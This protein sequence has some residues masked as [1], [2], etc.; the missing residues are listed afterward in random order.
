VSAG[1]YALLPLKDS[2]PLR[3]FVLQ[4]HGTSVGEVYSKLRQRSLVTAA[5]ALN[6]V[7]WVPRDLQAYRQFDRVVAVG[8]VVRDDLTRPPARWFLPR[9]RVR[10]I[11][12]GV[13][14]Q[15]FVP[16]D[17]GRRGVRR[18]L[19]FGEHVRLALCACRLHHQK[20]VDLCLR[21]FARLVRR[22][23]NA[24][25]VVVGGGPARRELQDLAATLG[26]GD[27]VVFTGGVSRDRMPAFFQAADA[28][29]L[30]TR[31][32]E[33]LPLA[34]LEA[35][36]T[37]VPAVVSSH[38]GSMLRVSQAVHGVD[39]RDAQSVATTL[40][41]VLTQPRVRESLLPAEYTLDVAIRAYRRVLQV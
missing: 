33:G 37:G 3:P 40:A 29:V 38:L 19:G 30:T 27:R 4:A 6:N 16:G 18:A 39:P 34:V 17:E 24:Q 35:L 13:D 28:L 22:N 41:R 25:L 7:A 14:T 31:H 23:A 36:A 10:L 20:G 12:N 21:A 1:A 11:R 32:R 15:V 26:M 5:K 8:D 2:L 9:E